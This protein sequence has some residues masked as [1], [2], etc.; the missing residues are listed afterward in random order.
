MADLSVLQELA[1]PHGVDASRLV[2]SDEASQ[3]LRANT[4]EAAERGAFGVPRYK[5]CTLVSQA[6]HIFLT[7]PTGNKE[8]IRLARKTLLYVVTAHGGVY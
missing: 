6:S 3:M 1:T 7:P 8:K 5:C 4:A 2:N